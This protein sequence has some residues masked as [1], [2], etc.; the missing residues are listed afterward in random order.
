MRMTVAPR[1]W[2]KIVLREVLYGSASPIDQVPFKPVR[3]AL[4]GY[5]H[6]GLLHSLSAPSNHGDITAPL[7]T[8]CSSRRVRHF[9]PFLPADSV[10]ALEKQMSMQSADLLLQAAIEP[11]PVEGR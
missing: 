6:G 7:I 10:L 8:L 1:N 9:F 5:P 4:V 2:P 11:L 3:R